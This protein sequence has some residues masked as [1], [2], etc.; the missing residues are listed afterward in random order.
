MFAL[1][2]LGGVEGI[3]EHSLFKVRNT[4]NITGVIDPDVVHTVAYRIVFAFLC[5]EPISQRGRDCFGR[6][7]LVSKRA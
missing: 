4:P 5:R 1:Q 3:L 6:K 2:A 7:H